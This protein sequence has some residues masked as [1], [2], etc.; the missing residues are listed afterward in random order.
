MPAPLMD[1]SIGPNSGGR[2]AASLIDGRPD[3]HDPVC[4]AG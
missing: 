1:G 3:T 4:V 2:R